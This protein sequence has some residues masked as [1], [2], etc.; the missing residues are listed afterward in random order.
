MHMEIIM[1]ENVPLKQS[2]EKCVTL[3]QLFTSY[4][5]LLALDLFHFSYFIMKHLLMNKY[6]T[7]QILY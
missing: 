4:W 2:N 3:K 6:C 5:V 1:L 7:L